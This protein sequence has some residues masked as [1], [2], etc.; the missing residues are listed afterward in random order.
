MTDGMSVL[1][2]YLFPPHFLGFAGFLIVVVVVR[3]LNIKKKNQN[4]PV[5]IQGLCKYRFFYQTPMRVFSPL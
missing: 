3:L 2:S 5:H 4:S 1:S